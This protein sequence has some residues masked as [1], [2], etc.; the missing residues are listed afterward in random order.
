MDQQ[1]LYNRLQKMKLHE[2]LS[3]QEQLREGIPRFIVTRVIG[4]WIYEMITGIGEHDFNS[5]PVFIPLGEEKIFSID[6][7]KDV[8]TSTSP[9]IS[10][11]S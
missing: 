8:D 7:N 1:E 3:S 5:R 6:P 4:G 11:N 10:F 9:F 2:Q